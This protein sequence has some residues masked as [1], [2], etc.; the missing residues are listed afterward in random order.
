MKIRPWATF[1]ADFPCDMIENDNDIVQFGGRNVAVAIGEMLERLGCVVSEP[2]YAHE[3]G[4]EIEVFADGRNLWCQVTDLNVYLIYLKDNVLFEG[5]G[6][7]ANPIYVD[8]LRKFDEAL[9]ADPRF[10]DVSWFTDD[11]VD[12]DGTGEAHAISEED[13]DPSVGKGVIDKIL[14]PA[15]H[16]QQ[17]SEH[18]GARLWRLL[19]GGSFRP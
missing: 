16:R 19:R 15:E 14:A 2:I 1:R 3:H 17:P 5:K 13:S 4:W 11:E 8:T 10:H 6:R 12:P 18:P 7:N 9:Q